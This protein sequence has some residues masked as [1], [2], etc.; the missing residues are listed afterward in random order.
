MKEIPDH[1]QESLLKM[2]NRFYFTKNES[3]I[4]DLVTFLLRMDWFRR[5][6]LESVLLTFKISFLLSSLKYIFVPIYFLK[7]IS[8][9]RFRH[10]D[11]L[12]AFLLIIPWQIGCSIS[13][14][15]SPC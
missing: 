3:G 11:I 9:S 8:I 12:A 2:S 7:L 1:L 14:F 10:A 15:V 5:W 4:L 6:H 13:G